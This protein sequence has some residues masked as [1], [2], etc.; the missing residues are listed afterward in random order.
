M[1]LWRRKV[2]TRDRAWRS[3]RH[4]SRALAGKFDPTTASRSF[5]TV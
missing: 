1:R 4:R 3:V 2:L 5:H